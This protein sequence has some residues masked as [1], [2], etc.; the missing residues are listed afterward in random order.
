MTAENNPDTSAEQRL[1]RLSKQVLDDSVTELD[2]RTLARLRAARKNA[3]ADGLIAK[4]GRPVG[5]DVTGHRFWMKPAGLLGS[6][7][8][9]VLALL[10]WFD[11]GQTPQVEAPDPVAQVPIGHTLAHETVE[12]EALEYETLEYEV[13]VHMGIGQL[14]ID[15]IAVLGASD[16]PEFYQDLEFYQWLED[17]DDVS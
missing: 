7:A 5:T 15:D 17:Q 12:H 13:R 8:A 3:V 14:D 11:P 16:D 6:A 2:Q 1:V 9:L 10:V 4:A